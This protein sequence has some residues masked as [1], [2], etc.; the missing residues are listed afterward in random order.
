[1]ATLIPYFSQSASSGAKRSIWAQFGA[2]FNVGSG[3]YTGFSDYA[4]QFVGVID[5]IFYKGTLNLGLALTDQNPEAA[6]GPASFS[7]NGSSADSASYVVDGNTL[8]VTAKFSNG[9]QETV[10]FQRSGDGRET[11][12]ALSGAYGANVHLAPA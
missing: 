10:K 9:S 5:T 7:I 4:A 8:I 3:S 11:Y 6:S 2:F 12:L 1:M